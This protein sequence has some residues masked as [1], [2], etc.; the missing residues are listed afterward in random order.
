MPVACGVAAAIAYAT[1]LAMWVGE[2]A[3]ERL[4]RYEVLFYL[5][6]I[7][8]MAGAPAVWFFVW[9]A[10]DKALNPPPR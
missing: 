1:L 2:P 4:A 5:A 10:V 9:N 6:M 3:L 8:Y 7:A